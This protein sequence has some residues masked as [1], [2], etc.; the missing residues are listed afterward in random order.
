[1]EGQQ[2]FFTAVWPTSSFISDVKLTQSSYENQ[3][4]LR[5]DKTKKEGFI[6]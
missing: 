4:K 6:L 5:F 3:V 1:M 2:E